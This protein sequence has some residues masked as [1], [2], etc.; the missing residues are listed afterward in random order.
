MNN[1]FTKNSLHSTGFKRNFQEV[2]NLISSNMKCWRKERKRKCQNV[3]HFSS[4]IANSLNTATEVH[5]LFYNSANFLFCVCFFSGFTLNVAHENNE[6][7]THRFC[8]TFIHERYTINH[9]N[10]ERTSKTMHTHVYTFQSE[11]CISKCWAL[12]WFR[13]SMQFTTHH[14]RDESA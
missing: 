6:T 5:Y 7:E 2:I 14:M 1:I 4:G 12:L 3:C 10:D 9:R 13:I 11:V 8:L